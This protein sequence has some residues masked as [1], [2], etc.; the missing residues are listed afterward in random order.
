MSARQDFPHTALAHRT[1]AGYGESMNQIVVISA[2]RQLQPLERKFVDSFIN[3][4]EAEAD[5]RGERISNALHRPLTQAMID[6]SHGML[7]RPMVRAAITE[8]INDLASATELTANRIIKELSSVA[9][10]SISDFMEIDEHGIP[11]YDFNRATPEQLAALASWKE[12][13][14]KFGGKTYEFKMHD[15]MAALKALA[16]YMGLF[17]AD[18]PHWR[19]SNA[20][21]VT[22]IPVDAT[23]SDASNAYQR[24]IE[25]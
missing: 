12:T 7:E 20:K 19:S 10:T 1:V 18:N 22:A 6:S 23:V 4:I 15:K 2:Y 8:R 13:P 17:E 11:H 21:P 5:K 16:I 3:R 9:F 24:M 25:G 14:Q